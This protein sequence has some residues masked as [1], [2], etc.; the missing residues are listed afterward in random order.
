M[1]LLNISAS[2]LN[3]KRLGLIYIFLNPF[4]KISCYIA[5]QFQ[6]IWIN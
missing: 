2:P 3:M 4:A 1:F 6:L 5:I